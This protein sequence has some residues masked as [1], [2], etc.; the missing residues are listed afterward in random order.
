MPLEIYVLLFCREEDGRDLF[1]YLL[2]VSH[3]QLKNN[4]YAKEAYFGVAF[5]ATLASP[6]Q[7]RKSKRKI[8]CPGLDGTACNSCEFLCEME[9]WWTHYHGY[10]HLFSITFLL[11]NFFTSKWIE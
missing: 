11:I 4:P 1:L 7:S 9:P 5:S 10:K 3:F 8:C 2:L 6:C